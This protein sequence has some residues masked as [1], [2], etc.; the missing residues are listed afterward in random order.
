M[1]QISEVLPPRDADGIMHIGRP[2]RGCRHCGKTEVHYSAD[3]RV[4]WHHPGVT[5]CGKAVQDQVE[6]RRA[7]LAGLRAKAAESQAALDELR[8]RA[9]GGFGKES[10]DVRAMLPRAQ[11]AHELRVARLR[12]LSEGVKVELAEA[13]RLLNAYRVAA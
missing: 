7:D 10:A 2:A 11:R 12:E 6:Y 3:G 13:E 9:D 4:A 5:C 8:Q 1:K